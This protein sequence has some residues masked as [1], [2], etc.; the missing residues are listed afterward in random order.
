[1]W[2]VPLPGAQRPRL[3]LQ[4]IALQLHDDVPT[5]T[6]HQVGGRVHATPQLHDLLRRQLIK[7]RKIREFPTVLEDPPQTGAHFDPTPPHRRRS[8]LELGANPASVADAE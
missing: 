5:R 6:A 2:G 7:F 3:C 8:M 1:V 4:P